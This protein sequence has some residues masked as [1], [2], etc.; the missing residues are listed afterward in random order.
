MWPF[1][2][3]LTKR[4]LCSSPALWLILTFITVAG[5]AVMGQQTQ[6]GR[7]ITPVDNAATTTQA[8][9]ELAGDTA[10]LNSQRRA[11]SVHYHDDQGRTVYVDTISGEEWID[12]L[13]LPKV[14][15]MEYPLLYSASVGVNIWDPVMRLFGQKYGL[16]GF[17]AQ[18]NLHNRYIPVVE[19]GLG[20]AANTPAGMNFSY[21]SPMSVYFKLG[22][23]YNFLYNSNPDYQFY[24]G[25]RYGFSP[26]SYS[27]DN[28]TIDQGYWDVVE[29][30]V[31]PSQHATVGWVEFALGLKVKLVGPVSA[32]WTFLYHGILHQSHPKYGDPWYIPGYGTR[33]GSITGAFTIYYTLPI[34]T[35]K[36]TDVDNENNI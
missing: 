6:S 17:S 15:K 11:R 7:R 20:H 36:V 22:A 9:N 10:V 2:S 35:R 23:N 14:A 18:V 13:A 34:N 8:I 4:H 25:L 28:I 33:N 31:I 3:A 27:I 12:S 16:V 24:A 26:F 32:G 29:H 5:T 19:V 30:P 1:I 21:R